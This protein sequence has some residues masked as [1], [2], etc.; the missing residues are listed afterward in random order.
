MTRTIKRSPATI[1]PSLRL[2]EDEPGAADINILG[3]LTDEEYSQVTAASKVRSYTV[4]QSVFQQG[5]PHEGIFI[6]LSGEVRTFYIGPTGREITLAYWAP[7]NF[8]G[9]PELFGAGPHV[10]S[11]Q[12]TQPTQVLHLTGQDLRALMLRIPRLAVAMVEA[13]SHK[14]KCY[15]ALVHMLGTRSAAERLAQLLLLKAKLDGKT[16]E[17]GIKIKKM[18]TQED[19]SKMVGASRQWVTMTLDRLREQGLIEGSSGQITILD[20]A[21]LRRFAGQSGGE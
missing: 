19:L 9:G 4:G 20:E 5:Q 11:G 1:Q 6:L 12:A 3:G 15:S 2:H 17:R 14:G 13:L 21:R 8:V 16:T 10:W 7:G 18:L